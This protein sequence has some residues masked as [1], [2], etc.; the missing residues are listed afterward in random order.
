[1]SM[2]PRSS[3]HDVGTWDMNVGYKGHVYRHVGG[4]SCV[5]QY[6]FNSEMSM[7]PRPW[8]PSMAIVISVALTS[9][10]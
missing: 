10:R 2:V 6:I 8:C 7:V 9:L 4:T 5:N 1:M 3:G